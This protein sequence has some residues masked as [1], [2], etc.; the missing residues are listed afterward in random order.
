MKIDVH[1]ESKTETEARVRL[2]TKSGYD[3]VELRSES[4]PSREEAERYI[5]QQEKNGDVYEIT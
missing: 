5:A 1:S 3:Y 2:C 4:F